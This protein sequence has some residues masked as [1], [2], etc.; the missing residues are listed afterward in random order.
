MGDAQAFLSI[1]VSAS[2]LAGSPASWLLQVSRRIGIPVINLRQE[3][4]L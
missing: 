2:N 3:C 1:K 4:Y